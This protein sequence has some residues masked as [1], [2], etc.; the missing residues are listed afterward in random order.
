MEDSFF[1]QNALN[2]RVFISGGDGP[3]KNTRYTLSHLDLKSARGR[4]VLLKPN[5]GRIDSPDSGIVTNPQVVAAVIDAFNEAGAKVAIG[6]SP[7]TGVDVMKA[8]D[9]SGIAD[10]AQER[11]CQLIDLDERK[12]VKV[13]IP[14]GMAIKKILVCAEALEHDIIV[15][16]PVMKM[17]MHTKVT[18][19]IKNM[20]GCLWRRSKVKFHMLPEQKAINEM[21]LNVAIAEMSSVLRPH[22][23]VI[24]GT[25][26]MEGLGPSAGDPKPID[27]VV[28]GDDGFAADAVA[29]RIMGINAENVPHLRIAADRGYGKIDIE[30]INIFPENWEK[31][32]DPF[33]PAPDIVSVNFPNINILDKN[34]CSACQST[35]LLFLKRY[36][37]IIFDYFPSDK[38]INIALG[39]G[40]ENVPEKCLCIGNCTKKHKGKGI[41]IPGCPPVGSA[42]LKKITGMTH[43]P[44]EII[45]T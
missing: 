6:E 35:L 33:T 14:Y 9:S 22:L 45:D 5:A 24:D 18:L 4:K 25:V 15:S 41:Y 19:S 8:F 13:N 37:N 26:G 44:G 16:I 43:L 10:I 7:I 1:K 40:H 42:I 38:P 2:P 30:N 29:C 20:K 21:P 27:V 34:S 28:A 11:N 12:P 17:H 36:S 39:A 32:I 31:F 3:Y 23:A